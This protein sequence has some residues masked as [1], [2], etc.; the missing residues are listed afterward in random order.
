MN[1]PDTIFTK[2]YSINENVFFKMGIVL[3]TLRTR[4]PEWNLKVVNASHC[5]VV[6][7]FPDY[8]R[9]RYNTLDDFCSQ[10]GNK[11]KMSFNEHLYEMDK[12][13]L[14]QITKDNKS[15]E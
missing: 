5:S 10:I 4:Y 13:Y 9:F 8:S 3:Y 1:F 14:D 15:S 2:N 6:V 12:I 11:R 7:Q